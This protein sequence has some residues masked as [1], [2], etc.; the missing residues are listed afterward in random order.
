MLPILNRYKPTGTTEDVDFT[1]KRNVHG[2]ERSH[3][4][5]VV[6]DSKWE[7]TAAFYL[8]QQRDH[9]SCYVRN[10]RPFLLI[11]YEYEGAQHHYEPDYLVKLRSGSTVLLEMKGAEFDMDHAKY[12]AARRWVSAVNNWGRLGKWDFMVCRDPLMLP[13]LLSEVQRTVR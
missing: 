10:D 7:Q 3:V 6:L 13:R 2:T 11:P 9:V 4:N 8:E 1:T 12:Q 5:A